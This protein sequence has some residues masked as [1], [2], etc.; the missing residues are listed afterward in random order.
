MEPQHISTVI[1]T[2]WLSA[3]ERTVQ[4]S[5]VLT[6]VQFC[7]LFVRELLSPASTVTNFAENIHQRYARGRL[8]NNPTTRHLYPTPSIARPTCR[9]ASKSYFFSIEKLTR[10]VQNLTP[11]QHNYH[12]GLSLGVQY[13]IYHSS[14]DTK[15]Q[16][17][18]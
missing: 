10:P 7:T 1:S 11:R 17:L 6:H 8:S 3:I 12:Q 9:V 5:D 4:T 15:F 2:L 13:S 16:V 18:D 14:K